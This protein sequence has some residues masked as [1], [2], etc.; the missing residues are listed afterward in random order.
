MK[1]LYCEPLFVEKILKGETSCI[2]CLFDDKNLQVND[3]IWLSNSVTREKFGTAFLTS[4]IANPISSLMKNDWMGYKGYGDLEQMYEVFMKYY[5]SRVTSETLVKVICFTFTPK[6]FNPITVVDDCDEVIGGMGL[7]EAK[8]KG[9]YRRIVRIFIFNELK[10]LLLQKRSHNVLFPGKWDQSASGHVDFGESYQTAA[11]RELKEEMGVC[12][13][14]LN[15]LVVSYKTPEGFLGVYD[16]VLSSEALLTYDIEEV[17][18]IK[19]VY[20]DEL[21]DMLES[22]SKLFTQDFLHIWPRLRDNWWIT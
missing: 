16:A 13:V 19:W 17:E 9:Y 11:Y 1:N 14:K 4:V 3:E 12:N 15:E 18:S 8:A 22:Q 2:F 20:F 21:S 6:V 7:M 10:Q 5:G